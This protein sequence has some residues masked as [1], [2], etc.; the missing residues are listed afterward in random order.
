MTTVVGIWRKLF[1]S[2]PLPPS[3]P[4]TVPTW[5]QQQ[6]RWQRPQTAK[7]M[8][9]DWGITYTGM[10]AGE[11]AGIARKWMRR[12]ELDAQAPELQARL[13]QKRMERATGQAAG[14]T[15]RQG[16]L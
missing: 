4:K 11:L 1:V 10:S 9:E 2:K 14:L 7:P 15:R 3:A 13:D 8:K 5:A 6:G 12:Q 16:R